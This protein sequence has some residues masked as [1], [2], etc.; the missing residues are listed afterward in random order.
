M[1]REKSPLVTTYLFRSD[2]NEITLLR[3][4]NVYLKARLMRK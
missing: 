4:Q 3:K 2:D 1:S